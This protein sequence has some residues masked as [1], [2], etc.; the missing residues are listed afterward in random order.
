MNTLHFDFTVFGTGSASPHLERPPSAFLVQLDADSILIDCGEATQYRLLEYKIKHTRIRHILISHLHGDHYFGLIGLLSS[1]S[2]GHRTEPLTLVGPPGL[3]E[4]ITV[5]FKYSQT[6]LSYPLHFIET[7]PTEHQLIVEH[8]RFTI[9]TI[10]LSHRVPC[11]GFLIR[12]KVT[13]RKLIKEKIPAN[14]PIP[15]LKK[16]ADG[17][18]VSDELTGELYAVDEWTLPASKPRALAYCSDTAYLPSIIPLIQGVDLL[19]HEAT[20]DQSHAERA[21]Q[22]F[23]STAQQAAQIAHDAEA[24]KLVIGHFSSRYKTVDHLLTE[25]VEIFPATVLAKEGMV[26]S[27]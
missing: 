10:P 13:K 14:F 15:Y 17:F 1:L 12:E 16:L 23:H 26:V 27:L 21:A 8:P 11:H 22:T 20:F 5:Q 3:A 2:L 7:R 19:Y 24:K 18:D 9:E 6:V 25:A 4:I